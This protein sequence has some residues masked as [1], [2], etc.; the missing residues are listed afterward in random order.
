MMECVNI[1][2]ADQ[3]FR[4]PLRRRGAEEKGEENLLVAAKMEER[5]SL[6]IPVSLCVSAVI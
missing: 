6:S 4:Q 2:A 3:Q 5:H 1:Q